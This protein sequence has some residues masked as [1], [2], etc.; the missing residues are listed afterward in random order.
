M[1]KFFRI[2]ALA[3]LLLLPAAG[4]AQKK[5]MT[6]DIWKEAP[7]PN[8]NGS[9][10]DNNPAMDVYF[11][12]KGG[13]TG[14]AVLVC[15]G[16]GYGG[17]ADYHEGAQ[18]GQFLSDNGITAAVLKYR[19]PHGHNQVPLSDAEQ[20]MKLMRQY[21]RS[22]DVDPHK[23]GVMGFS[24]GG[25]LA[26]T[27]STKGKGKSRPDFSVLFYPVITFT[28]PETHTGSRD[29]LVGDNTSLWDY[30]SADKQ[31]TRKTPPALLFHSSD[32]DGVPIRNSELYVEA[33]KKNGRDVVLITYPTGQHG[34]GFSSNFASHE[35]M[36]EILLEYILKF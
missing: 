25:H 29:N 24:A 21:A 7:A 6:I 5:L 8:S 33:M 28:E 18:F 30:Y 11:P 9:E 36:K 27:L 2:G 17:L 26:A 34:W 3:L 19:M 4:F 35:D 10:N 23:I 16:G 13:N 12:E 32:D 31:V 14:H 15:P 1:I 22:W 20:A